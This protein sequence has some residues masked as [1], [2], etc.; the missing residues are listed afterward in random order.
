MSSADL[1]ETAVA[2]RPLSPLQSSAGTPALAV[3]ELVLVHEPLEL[4]LVMLI[5]AFRAGSSAERCWP[6]ALSGTESDSFPNG[7]LS[8]LR[9]RRFADWADDSNLARARRALQCWPGAIEEGPTLARAMYLLGVHA[10]GIGANGRGPAGRVVALGMGWETTVAAA[11]ALRRGWELRFAPEPPDALT[12]LNTSL[13]VLVVLPHGAVTTSGLAST[14]CA[15]PQPT[16][17][18]I[19]S[20]ADLSQWIARIDATG[21]RSTASDLF[22]SC[23]FGGLSGVP[24]IG[25]ERWTADALR[26]A[27]EE[28]HDVLM[29][30]L[31][32]LPDRIFVGDLTI[33]SVLSSPQTIPPSALQARH[34]FADT[35]S[36]AQLD[37]GPPSLGQRVGL[38]VLGG[39]VVSYVST[40]SVKDNSWE[41]C[42]LY[43][44]LIRSGVPLGPAV[45][46]V[47]RWLLSS[48]RD[49][50]SY[51]LLGDP[52]QVL[53][54]PSATA[55]FTRP[56]VEAEWVVAFNG[57]VGVA[58]I[59]DPDCYE[60]AASGR[61]W[62]EPR[63]PRPDAP[64]FS[65]PIREQRSVVLVFP[66]LTAPSETTEFRLSER[67]IVNRRLADVGATLPARLRR[68]SGL[69][70]MPSGKATGLAR[71]LEAHVTRLERL[72]V[73][74]A[75]FATRDRDLDDAERSAVE[76]L[77]RLQE[78]VRDHALGRL[79][80]PATFTEPYRDHYR[81]VCTREGPSCDCGASTFVKTL[82]MPFD[83]ESE[84]AVRICRTCGVLS[85]A[86]V[87]GPV[88]VTL[89]GLVRAGE[90]LTAEFGLLST[91]TDYAA[92][93]AGALLTSH[94]QLDDETR[95]A[96][97]TARTDAVG[98]TEEVVRMVIRCPRDN[99]D[100][101]RSFRAVFVSDLELTVLQRPVAPG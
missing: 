74:G 40:T 44:A 13:P 66:R 23:R 56:G 69:R 75:G 28:P 50:P 49:A 18:L 33:S 12:A 11:L 5:D 70:A 1:T 101:P 72:A 24:T 94:A 16:G 51:I 54:A 99:G 77:E 27:L 86:A 97:T 35:C 93:S 53:G 22:V 29:F 98:A 68:L 83:S 10:S 60:L 45:G 61:L 25:R 30:Y 57:P 39:V 36:G 81:V 95:P 100:S 34:I 26:E 52:T 91:R 47:N 7:A 59:D 31:H 84:R 14:L 38:N 82:A 41:E 48:G 87:F 76:A 79:A 80:S 17:C 55:S 4:A 43:Y 2:L 42:L 88:S 85:D 9:R 96:R 6:V 8:A 78:Q 32:G 65:V 73:A 15:R 20:W 89:R 64:V 37:S 21:P 46:L 58:V 90:T 67:P 62:A 92:V 71:N 3:S 63:G 19:G